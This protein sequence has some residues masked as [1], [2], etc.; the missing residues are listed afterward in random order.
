MQFILSYHPHHHHLTKTSSHNFGLQITST[1]L[2]APNQP[3]TH[4]NPIKN[5]GTAKK[6]PAG[7]LRGSVA[8]ELGDVPVAA[9]HLPRLVPQGLQI[10]IA[11]IVI[12]I[13]LF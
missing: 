9:L 6:T 4:A 11:V 1:P 10:E 5:N 13:G 12:V 2:K 7:R 8:L 3:L